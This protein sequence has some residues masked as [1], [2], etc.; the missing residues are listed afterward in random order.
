[1]EY[2]LEI[3]AKPSEDIAPEIVISQIFSLC[4]KELVRLKSNDTGISFPQAGNTIGSVIRIHGS[5]STLNLI[6]LNLFSLSD[7][8]RIAPCRQIPDDCNWRLIKR[9]QP[10]ISKAKLRRLVKRGSISEQDAKN[11]METPIDLPH[12]YVQLRS[13]S[14][15]QSFRIFL[16]QTTV[17]RPKEPA[18][19]NSYGLGGVVPWF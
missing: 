4:H 19:F 9:I 7:Y 10:T 6:A 2:Y 3:K 14:T 18:N 16:S 13:A 8:C 15:K 5:E 12:P 17:V 1:M 11:R